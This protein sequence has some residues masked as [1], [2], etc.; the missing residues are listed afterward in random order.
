MAYKLFKKEF[1]CYFILSILPIVPFHNRI[2]QERL[3][4]KVIGKGNDELFK[5]E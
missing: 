1:K 5:D 2:R 3:P 4:R